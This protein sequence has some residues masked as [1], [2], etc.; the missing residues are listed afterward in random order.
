MHVF[1]GKTK[2][3]GQKI[4]GTKRP[5]IVIERNT[6]QSVFSLDMYAE[7]T[8]PEPNLSVFIQWTVISAGILLGTLVV[9]RK[10]GRTKM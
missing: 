2:N 7:C 5:L 3:F 9:E 6:M 4:L 1:K 8:K 10:A